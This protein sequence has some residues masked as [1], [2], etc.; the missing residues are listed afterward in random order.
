MTYANDNE[1]SDHILVLWSLIG[2][3]HHNESLAASGVASSQNW[4]SAAEWK[5]THY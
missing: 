4:C 3:Y 1:S 2:S 5:T